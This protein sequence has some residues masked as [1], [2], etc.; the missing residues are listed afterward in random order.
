MAARKQ[1]QKQ[2]NNRQQ[3]GS[4][5]TYGNVAYELQPDY[6]PERVRE[7]EKQRR[8]KAQ[9][10]KAEAR[11][12]RRF[13]VRMIAASLTVFI[14]CIAFMGVNVMVEHTEVSL[15]RQK[16]TLEDLKSANTILEA[17]LTEQ[18]DLDYVKEEATGRL[19]MSEPQP[20]QIVYI[21][22]PRQSYTVQHDTK[23]AADTPSLPEKI[24]SFF[25]QKLGKD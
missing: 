21:D 2:Q 6:T 7:H 8:E 4:Y 14:G 19:G 10:A 23:K 24:K 5:Y 20:Y 3:S 18:L 17:E 16:S 1:R 11:E 13:S 22:V 25:T 12:R 9:A 15:R